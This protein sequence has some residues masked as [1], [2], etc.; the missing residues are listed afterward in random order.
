LQCEYICQKIQKLI[1]QHQQN[2]QDLSG[3]LLVIDIITPIDGG[4]S[5]IP[6]L[7]YHP[8]SLT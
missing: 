1:S 3:S 7:E 5:H 8:D 2:N 6:K 4:D